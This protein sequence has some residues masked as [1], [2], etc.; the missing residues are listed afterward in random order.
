MAEVPRCA[1]LPGVATDHLATLMARE[2]TVAKLLMFRVQDVSEMC[3][4]GYNRLAKPQT[5][6]GSI[7]TLLQE[8]H[9]T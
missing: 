8:E 9:F 1:S 4:F 5:A 3:A 7:R 2:G 6:Q